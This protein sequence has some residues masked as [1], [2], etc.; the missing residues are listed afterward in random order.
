M[1]VDVG[2]TLESGEK[3]DGFIAGVSLNHLGIR[4]SPAYALGS[5]RLL[6][7]LNG[8]SGL[9]YNLGRVKAGM[10]FRFRV[11]HEDDGH[12]RSSTLEVELGLSTRIFYLFDSRFDQ[13]R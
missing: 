3:E 8:L 10:E 2:V 5:R 1:P 12:I 11:D 9:S 6:N 13:L 4:G 7:G